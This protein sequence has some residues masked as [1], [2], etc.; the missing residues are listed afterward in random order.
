MLHFPSVLISPVNGLNFSTTAGVI[1]LRKELCTQMHCIESHACADQ[2]C[3]N[4]MSHS[5]L[6][7][8]KG[9][10]W[11]QGRVNTDSH[12]NVKKNVTNLK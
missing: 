11:G 4:M 5:S 6:T 10:G 3:Y 9:D 8:G 12:L 1:L 2:G 7:R